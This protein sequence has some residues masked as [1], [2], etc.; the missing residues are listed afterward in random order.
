MDAPVSAGQ[1]AFQRRLEQHRGAT[2]TPTPSRQRERGF[3][4]AGVRRTI[5][6]NACG[7]GSCDAHVAKFAVFTEFAAIDCE[8]VMFL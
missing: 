2:L 3:Y 4:R 8:D 6:W 7:R 5:S 1:S